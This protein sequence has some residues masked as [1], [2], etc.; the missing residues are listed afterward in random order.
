M[1]SSTWRGHKIEYDEKLKQ[2]Y[3]S[4]TKE[5]TSENPNRKCGYCELQNT[6]EGHDA[7]LGTLIGVENAC[8]G[9]G[10]IKDA[11]IQFLDG[12]CIRGEDAVVIQ[13]ILKK[14]SNMS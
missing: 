10:V 8:C 5:L 9:H 11:Y 3:Y 7:C 4:D 12:E 14:W 2:W 1:K 13:N 6:L